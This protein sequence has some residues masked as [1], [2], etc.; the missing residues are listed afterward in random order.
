VINIE[1]LKDRGYY[2]FFWTDKF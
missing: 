2:N 1:I